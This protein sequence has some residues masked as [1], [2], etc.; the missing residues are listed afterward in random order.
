MELA[1]KSTDT[2]RRTRAGKDV[3]STE[4]LSL[5]LSCSKAE[6]LPVFGTLHFY[7]P[8]DD[9]SKPFFRVTHPSG[10]GTKNYSHDLHDVLIED[11]R[12]FLGG[13]NLDTH[14]FAGVTDLAPV[15]PDLIKLDRS[16]IEDAAKMIIQGNVAR[17]R[18]VII[19][20]VVLRTAKVDEKHCRPVRKVHID[21]S[22][23]AAWLRATTYLDNSEY[24]LVVSGHLRL[25][26]INIWRPVGT[27][28]LDH[29]LAFADSRSIANQ[30][31]V[32]VEHIFPNR[33]GETLA[34]K[35]NHRQRFYW[36]PF[37]S[38][39]DALLLQCFDSQSP[40]ACAHAS[41]EPH[42]F[43]PKHQ[44]QSLEVRCMVLTG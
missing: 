19:F 36:W 44:R 34:V 26:I 16:S 18:R 39:T 20:D 40:T 3:E 35:F 24:Q 17:C 1:L 32:E 28:V 43:E 27:P 13:L 8:P 9:G 12:S 11:M 29:P 6:L 25:R 14:S 30:D 5:E 21:Q 38:T 15:G 7:S 22:A 10:A 42:N 2:V 33:K 41:F 37:M 23:G 31:L 4:D